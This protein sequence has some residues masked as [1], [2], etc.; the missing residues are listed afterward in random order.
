MRNRYRFGYTS[1]IK[2]T[3]A[4]SR[5]FMSLALYKKHSMFAMLSYSHDF[6]LIV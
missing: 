2:G 5:V 6:Q 4:F 3:Y 1:V